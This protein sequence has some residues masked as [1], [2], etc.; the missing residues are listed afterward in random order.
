[1]TTIEQDGKTIDLA[2]SENATVTDLSQGEAENGAAGNQ[3]EASQTEA[4]A[5]TQGQAASPTPGVTSIADPG[6][7][8]DILTPGQMSPNATTAAIQIVHRPSLLSNFHAFVSGRMAALEAEIDQ[9]GAL[10][11]LH[12][13][14]ASTGD[15]TGAT[16]HIDTAKQNLASA[17]AT[18][19]QIHE[20]LSSL[21][22]QAADDA[23]SEEV[24]TLVVTHTV[25]PAPA[26][27]TEAA[28]LPA[29][30][31]PEHSA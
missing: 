26:T 12:G 11:G 18:V 24:P 25:T 20:A 13:S 3:A 16:T 14:A 29:A 8:P 22:A 1:M 31:Q 28:E 15:L 7:A 23:G 27:Q 9:I 4:E 30:E 19:G 21:K 10:L 17:K 2:G 5:A 6:P